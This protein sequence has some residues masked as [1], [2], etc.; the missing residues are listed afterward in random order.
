[1]KKLMFMLKTVTANVRGIP[2]AYMAVD[3]LLSV[4]NVSQVFLL[5][6]I[7]NLFVY[8]ITDR[9]ALL[10]GIGLFALYL[11]CNIIL[12]YIHDKMKFELEKGVTIHLGTEIAEQMNA[13]PYSYYEDEKIYNAVERISEKPYM[14]FFEGFIHFSRITGILINLFVVFLFLLGIAPII[15]EISVCLIMIIFFLDYKIMKT[16]DELEMDKIP[17]ERKL[18]YYFDLFFDKNLL[19]E[20][21]VLQQE[22]FFSE[23]IKNNIKKVFRKRV[24]ISI[25]T[26]KYYGFSCVFISIWSFIL[27]FF[28]GKQVYHGLLSLGILLAC[29]KVIDMVS[30]LSGQFSEEYVECAACLHRLYYFKN[31]IDHGEANE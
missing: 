4:V 21:R 15:M 14:M 24:K 5:Q 2:I 10:Q 30:A 6:V 18:K 7:V 23:K 1:M 17:E 25:L 8:N 19:L 20:I 13:V 28:V 3:I 27:L 9:R 29:I 31:L 11:L 12:T 26:Q 22:H 16:S